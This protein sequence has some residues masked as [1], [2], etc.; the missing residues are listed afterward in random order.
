MSHWHGKIPAINGKVFEGSA[1]SLLNTS[2][3]TVE[4][5]EDWTD[6]FAFD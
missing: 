6:G 1:G 3:A 4:E 5:V 2:V